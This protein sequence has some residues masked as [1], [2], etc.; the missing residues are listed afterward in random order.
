ML[1]RFRAVIARVIVLTFL[2]SACGPVTVMPSV[3]NTPSREVPAATLTGT[4]PLPASS[5]APLPLPRPTGTPFANEVTFEILGQL[6]GYANAVAVKDKVAYLGVGPQV[7][8]LDVS[9]PAMPRQI[10]QSGTFSGFVWDIAIAGDLVYVAAGNAGLRI[11]DL[12]KPLQPRRIDDTPSEGSFEKIIIQGS[13]A[14]VAEV[15][16]KYP[17]RQDVIRL[18]DVSDPGNPHELNSTLYGR[19]LD[20]Q[21]G[22]VYAI[23]DGVLTV[24]DISLPMSLKVTDTGLKNVSAVAGRFVY[25][26]DVMNRM[27]GIVDLSDLGN[28]QP[29]GSLKLS[30]NLFGQLEGVIKISPE[31]IYV[32]NTFQG[33]SGFISSALFLVDVSNPDSPQQSGSWSG[34]DETSDYGSIFGSFAGEALEGNF[35]YLTLGNIYSGNGLWIVDMHD[36]THLHKVGSFSALTGALNAI[37][38][39]RFAYVL[40]FGF[41]NDLV[42]ID[43]TNL[44]NIQERKAVDDVSSFKEMPL[45]G[46]YLYFPGTQATIL[47]LADPTSPLRIDNPASGMENSSNIQVAGE[48]A[49][50]SNSN[51]GL[52]FVD[53]SDPAQP[54]LISHLDTENIGYLACTDTEAIYMISSYNK[55]GGVTS[56]HIVDISDI[57]RPVEVFSQNLS[58]DYI[59]DIAYGNGYLYVTVSQSYVPSYHEQLLAFDVSDKA[60]PRQISTVEIGSHNSKISIMG[61]YLYLAGEDITILDITDPVHPRPVGK[62]AISGD[63]FRITFLKQDTLLVTVYYGG[64]FVLRINGLR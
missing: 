18:F 16:Q 9:N 48:H 33:E 19:L 26:L 4:P 62:T 52:T 57:T 23:Q 8:I 46:H 54:R 30:T 59:S 28:P 42:A 58:I 6:G 32:K 49:C 35:L 53:L 2:V 43:L 17:V 31:L 55:L 22:Q 45:K 36:P 20:V 25:T 63:A 41:P 10:G 24:T 61:H 37:S 3:I 12:T 51:G 39:D 7:L 27:L 34:S 21:G 14:F 64:I 11:M 60:H 29:R 15:L 47:D 38:F 40:R 5:T 13:V 44:N 1:T 56:L 50:V